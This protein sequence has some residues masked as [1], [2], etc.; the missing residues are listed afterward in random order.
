MPE[1]PEVET[2]KRILKPQLIGRRIISLDILNEQVI[3]YPDAEQFCENIAGHTITDM[4]RRGKYLI[5]IL[6][7]GDRVINHLRMTGQL[8]ITPPD[9]P[10]E[11]HTHLI[12]GLSDGKQLRYIDIRRF[13]RFWYLGQ[14]D[15]DSLTGMD[16]LGPEPSDEMM[17]SDHLRSILCSRDRPIKEMLLDQTILAGIGNIYSDEILFDARIHPENRCSSLDESDWDSLTGSI[18]DVMFRY[19]EANSMTPEEYL[20][21]KGKEYRNK[22]YLKMYGH[23]GEPCPVCGTRIEKITVGGRSG[24]FCPKC[25]RRRP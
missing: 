22:S 17:T 1:L 20:E 5:M 4:E 14:D 11:K 15:D 7:D 10:I 3:A 19:T 24:C 12:A 8:I 23:A 6:D 18:K 2:V 25:Q 16:K 21:G 9:H 13:D